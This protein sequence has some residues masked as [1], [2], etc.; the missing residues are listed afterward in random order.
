MKLRREL[1]HNQRGQL[2]HL[3][4]QVV[5]LVGEEITDQVLESGLPIPLHLRDDL[6]DAARELS[7]TRCWT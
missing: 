7:F 6:V 2:V 5:N 1:G 3:P 4:Q